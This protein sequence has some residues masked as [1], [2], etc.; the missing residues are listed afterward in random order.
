MYIIAPKSPL[1]GCYS[2]SMRNVKPAC[3]KLP[4]KAFDVLELEHVSL[5]EGL[6]DLLVGPSDEHFV[7]VVG[8]LR[9]ADT[10]ED[11]H[12]EVHPLPVGL[13]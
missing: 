6:P 8:L 9:Q 7:V 5:D 3:V 13:K 10:E 4:V 2:D 1:F 12:A 11:R